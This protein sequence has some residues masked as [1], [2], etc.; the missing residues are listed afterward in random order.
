MERGEGTIHHVVKV[1]TS[2]RSLTHILRVRTERKDGEIERLER[3]ARREVIEDLRTIEQLVDKILELS[4][5]SAVEQNREAEA[6]GK[7][8]ASL[9]KT[10][11]LNRKEIQLLQEELQESA[12]EKQRFGTIYEQRIQQLER[13]LA[14]RE[15]EFATLEADLTPEAPAR[16]ADG[17]SLRQSLQAKNLEIDRLVRTNAELTSQVSE[18]RKDAEMNTHANDVMW[19]AI[20]NGRNENNALRTEIEELRGGARDAE[21]DAFGGFVLQSEVQQL[22]AWTATRRFEKV[23]SI[24]RANDHDEWKALWDVPGI[25]ALKVTQIGSVFGY[26]HRAPHPHCTSWDIPPTADLVCSLRNLFN[27]PPLIIKQNV[28]GRLVDNVPVDVCVPI[29]TEEIDSPYL[30]VLVFRA[31]SE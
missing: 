28:R 23:C 26:F 14:A 2:L 9:Q 5:T 6:F 15:E 12:V 16:E 13:E 3:E 4:E 8:T 29:I 24:E 1:T 27:R 18:L 20:M 22:K 10:V 19:M 31:V 7:E 25:L 17:P 30:C 21:V 11:E